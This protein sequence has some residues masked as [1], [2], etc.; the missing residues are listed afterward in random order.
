MD[1]IRKGKEKLSLFK[2][3]WDELFDDLASTFSSLLHGEMSVPIDIEETDDAIIV[4]AELPG[5]SQKDI[6][7]TVEEGV[8]TIKGEKKKEVEEKGKT[9]HRME[10]RYGSFS[11]SISLPSTIN[12]DKVRASFK[13]GL[14]TVELGKKEEARSRTIKIHV[15]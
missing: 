13:D 6:N 15:E 2:D 14:L 1:I 8:L 11:R 5:I 3:K 9:Y 10:R 12:L 4:K 7:V